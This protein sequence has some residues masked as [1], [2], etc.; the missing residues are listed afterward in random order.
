[1]KN[2][3]TYVSTV[4]LITGLVGAGVFVGSR[5]P[6]TGLP[7]PITVDGQTI[8]FTHTDDTTGETLLI[9]TDKEVYTDG[10]S[11]ATLYLA[12]VN[13]SG[14]D[15]DIELSGYFVD[16]KRRITDISVLSE[17]IQEQYE[18]VYEERCEEQP[19]TSSICTRVQVA[20]NTSA[21]TYN[22][23]VPL[24]VKDR[25]NQEKTKEVAALAKDNK[26]SRKD[27]GQY[28]AK[29]KSTPFFVPA[30]GVVYYKVVVQFPPNGSTN[31]IIEAVGSKGGYGFLN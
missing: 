13:D 18:P 11:H 25:T 4:L 26:I 9:Y 1:M 5:D 17:L 2:W 12:V 22:A 20:T 15:Q 16:D 6:K 28:E 29:R 24:T 30:D 3:R 14:E 7:D 21:T 10:F 8:E 31:M 23:W 19:G 27:V